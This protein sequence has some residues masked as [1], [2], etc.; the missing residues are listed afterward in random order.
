[1]LKI[2]SAEAVATEDKMAP[3]TLDTDGK[4][5]LRFAAADGWVYVKELQQEGKKRL[6]LAE[7]LRGFRL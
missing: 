3:G 2:Y 5:Y 7:F 6:P 1:M 4:T